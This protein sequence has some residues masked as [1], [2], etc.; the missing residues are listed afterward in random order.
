MTYNDVFPLNLR[1]LN[2]SDPICIKL[3]I[4][5]VVDIYKHQVSKFVF[6]CL[7]GTNPIQFRNWFILNYDKYGHRTR[8]NF[9]TDNGINIKNLFYHQH[10]HQI[11]D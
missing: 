8:S 7:N 6:K 9:N 10:K 3:N 2:P 5:K 1:P 11:M 4:L